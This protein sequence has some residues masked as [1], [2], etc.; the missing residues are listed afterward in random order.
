MSGPGYYRIGEEAP[1]RYDPGG[2]VSERRPEPQDRWQKVDLNAEEEVKEK[3]E[4][5]RH[6]DPNRVG[7]YLAEYDAHGALGTARRDKRRER[8][9]SPKPRSP[10]SIKQSPSQPKCYRRPAD[11][12]SA[13]PSPSS[14]YLN[15]AFA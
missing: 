8:P 5:P 11:Y 14:K 2:D 9:S 7:A 12:R 3:P 4:V 15:S 6:D 10:S 13:T 1:E